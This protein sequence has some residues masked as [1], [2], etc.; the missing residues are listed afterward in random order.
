[1][2]SKSLFDEFPNISSKQWKQKLQFDLKGADYNDL[3]I[4]HSNEGIDVKPFYVSED[5]ENL[6]IEQSVDCT[7]WQICETI[8][9]ADVEKSNQHAIALLR[10]G[11]DTIKFILPE[12]DIDIKGLLEGI[13]KETLL[14]FEFQFLNPALVGE[15]KK[16]HPNSNLE[17]DIIGNLARSGNW[18]TNLKDDHQKF[19]AIV[20]NTKQ[21]NIDAAL[22]QNAGANITQQ[23]A[24]ALSH[25]NAYLDHLTSNSTEKE[26]KDLK[27]SFRM[28]IGSNYFFE[29]AKLKAMRLLWECLSNEYH[30]SSTCHI[31]A[32]PTKRNKT[33]FDYNANML[34]TTTECMSAILG[35]ANTINNLAY[36]T[37]FKKVNDFGERIS[38]NQLLVLKHES[39]LDKVVNPTEGAYYIETL[40]NQL[41][42]KALDI[43]KD[44]EAGGGFLTQL[45]EGVIQ[46]KI[47]E[48]SQKEL[49]Q[50]DN[51]ELVLVGTNKYINPQDQM[52]DQLEL[53]PFLKMAPRK[54]LLEPIIEKRISDPQEQNRL[55]T[56]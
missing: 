55:K 51:K 41:A 32:Q 47:K 43:F 21:I 36:D 56:E 19:E 6:P 50:F 29:I 17:T 39:Y 7:Q 45:K 20:K 16:T 26:I 40:T 53:Y 14:Y 30:V 52:T 44:I 13:P 15:V 8:Y 24:Y 12:K 27:F 3:L 33:L 9:V 22:Y 10:Q 38:L 42:Q 11:A 1:M 4:W 49:E 48:S 34:R 5:I 31:F 2:M 37:V 35:G 28:A 18:F 23:L 54:T 25:A 46:K